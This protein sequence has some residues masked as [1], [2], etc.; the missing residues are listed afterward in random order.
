MVSTNVKG[1]SCED[2]IPQGIEAAGGYIFITAYCYEEE[3]NSVIYVLDS[4]T[5]AYITTLVMPHSTHS[6]GIAYADSCLWVCSGNN[7]KGKA[8]L[9]YYS[10]PEIKE[11]I[12]YA[13]T[14]SN[15]K[16]IYLGLY[17]KGQVYLKN[18]EKCSFI[19]AYKDY[20]CVGEYYED[21]EG[22]LGIYNADATNGATLSAVKM[23]KIPE[24][25]QG[26]AIYSIN[27]NI[28]LLI[29]T[30]SGIICRSEIFVYC[31]SGT[32]LTGA[33]KYRKHIEMPKMVEEAMVLNGKVYFVFE[34]GS[35]HWGS[36]IKVAA[37]AG[38]ASADIVGKVCGF[39]T[40]FIFK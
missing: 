20:I 31:I 36:L 37:A 21:E 26:A 4:S 30:S 24:K 33:M 29:T 19:T 23:N 6:G 25:A 11:A 35:N 1:F 7:S 28:Y 38:I 14:N 8:I 27:N 9:Y 5:K 18:Q 15:V 22:C 32:Q 34:S 10:F 40:S 13:K 12:E 2:M 3:H 39:T 16:S 17:T